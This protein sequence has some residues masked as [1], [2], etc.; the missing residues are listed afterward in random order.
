MA[1]GLVDK[2]RREEGRRRV[3]WGRVGCRGLRGKR[4]WKGR[5]EK[6]GGRT[7]QRDDDPHQEC[8]QGQSEWEDEEE[9]DPKRGVLQLAYLPSPVEY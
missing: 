1:A 4:R 5:C 9:Y 2:F 3:E 7:I 8:R 6:E